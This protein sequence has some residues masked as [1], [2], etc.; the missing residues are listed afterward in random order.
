MV[1]RI[2]AISEELYHN[3]WRIG[4]SVF[5]VPP[6]VVLGMPDQNINRGNSNQQETYYGSSFYDVQPQDV[7]GISRQNMN[8]ADSNRQDTYSGH[9][10]CDILQSCDIDW[11]VYNWILNN[12]NK[13]CA[14]DFINHA[15]DFECLLTLTREEYIEIISVRNMNPMQL[16]LRIKRLQEHFSRKIS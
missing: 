12:S 7:I 3:L 14:E 16:W 6:E 8:R 11:N 15:I 5:D 2:T 1:D 13:S 4:K 10:Q 9:R